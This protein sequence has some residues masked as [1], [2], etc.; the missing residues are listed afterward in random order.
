MFGAD[1]VPQSSFSTGVIGI[2]IWIEGVSGGPHFDVG[3]PF[4]GAQLKQIQ[5]TNPTVG[6]TICGRKEPGVLDLAVVVFSTPI[7][8]L[9]LFV[10][11]ANPACQS[12]SDLPVEPTERLRRDDVSV[13]V[14]PPPDF[15]VQPGQETCGWCT[16]LGP[17]EFPDRPH[18]REYVLLGG[19]YGQ[20]AVVLPHIEAEEVEALLDM[21]GVGLL[22]EMANPRVA[23]NST[24]TGRI[25]SSSNSRVAAVM[26]KSSAYRTR[27]TLAPLRGTA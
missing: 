22:R 7:P 17:N 6:E 10:S 16:H 1:T 12:L 8:G 13:V 5:D 15:G 27:L 11:A 19:P 21:H 25:V 18:E 14:P 9:A 26:T 4:D 24:T 2:L 20:P 3:T 23:R